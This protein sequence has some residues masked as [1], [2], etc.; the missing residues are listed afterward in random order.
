MVPGG[1][2]ARGR[3]PRPVPVGVHGIRGADGTHAAD[4]ADGTPW[5]GDEIVRIQSMSKAILAVAALRLVERGALGL[6]AS[7][8]SWM[9]E[10]AAPRVL[11][12]PDAPL[13]GTVAADAP[14]TLRHL[15]TCTSGYGMARTPSPL[16]DAM[17]EAGLEA[18]AL[19]WPMSSSS[20]IRGWATGR[21][22]RSP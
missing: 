11:R 10:L 18:G 12:R 2:V 9:P 19:P 20:T 17:R 13:T 3:D 14:L 21:S 15:L 4:G 1:I 22:C 7:I 5:R 6:D 16:Q 8:A